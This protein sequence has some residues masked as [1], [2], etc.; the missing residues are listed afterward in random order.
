MILDLFYNV[1]LLLYIFVYVSE[2]FF[3]ISFFKTFH[4]LFSAIE[5]NGSGSMLKY[6]NLFSG[7]VI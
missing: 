7:N 6:I 4:S 2:I 1:Y 5:L 3:F